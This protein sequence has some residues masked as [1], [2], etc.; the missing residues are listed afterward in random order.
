MK[1]DEFIIDQTLFDLKLNEAQFYS[2]QGLYEESDKIYASLIEELKQLPETRSSAI[3]IKQLES[4]RQECKDKAGTRK[5]KVVLKYL[6]DTDKHIAHEES[7]NQRG[8]SKDRVSS[9]E[10][11]IRR[12][13]I[14]SDIDSQTAKFINDMILEAVIRG[15]SDIH[16][17]PSINSTHL[18]SNSN[19]SKIRFRI[20]GICQSYIEIPNKFALHL[21][22]KLKVM[23]KMDISIKSKPLYGKIRFKSGQ[24]DLIDLQVVTIPTIGYR[25]DIVLKFFP[26]A[27][28][29]SL[30]DIG[31]L[32]HNLNSF[33]QMLNKPYGLIL[34]VGLSD[35]G[36]T[37]IL[38]S[39]LNLINS[40]AKKIW[41]AED[42]IEITQQGIRQVETKPDKGC[43]Y[44]D[45]IEAFLK[46]DSD[47]IMIGE[48][49]DYETASIAVK[50]ALTGHLVIAGV[51]ASTVPDTIRK[52]LE[53]GVNPNNFADSLL[54]ILNQR[55]IRSLCEK[56][57]LSS[58]KSIESETQSSQPSETNLDLIEMLISDFGKDKDYL[59]ILEQIDR[60]NITLFEHLP[61]GCEECGYTGYKG[62]AGIHELLI[63]SENIKSLIKE[64]SCMKKTGDGQEDL[65]RRF[66]K[67]EH[68]VKLLEQYS[69]RYRYYTFKQDSILKV[70]SGITDMAEI[71]R[72]VL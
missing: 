30:S 21:I 9:N 11:L 37:T 8:I 72:N 63:N 62:R 22:F 70:M 71:R 19:R 10:S 5:G 46:S 55:L 24:N 16:I 50:A 3:Q 68:S 15:A 6:S 36:K 43:D 20:D 33:I 31:L 7:S 61:D 53:I 59:G 51:T 25:E 12:E 54:G 57:K 1:T 35:S 13:D 26:A 42:S 60:E 64:I 52:M 14:E 32:D 56:C 17:E 23:A 41:S 58:I 47:V 38:H 66:K 4:I 29:M 40:P 2:E 45:L 44:C 67:I 49:N 18:S 39:A 27:K 48:L 65:S 34:V 69:D 28:I